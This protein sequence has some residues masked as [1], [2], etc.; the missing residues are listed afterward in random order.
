M[1]RCEVLNSGS[2]NAN[3][4]RRTARSDDSDYI[5]Q[6]CDNLV[7]EHRLDH[8]SSLRTLEMSIED[9][10]IV[11]TRYATNQGLVKKG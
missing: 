8:D 3:N 1:I 11:E 6:V 7:V 2:E 10:T 5:E 9:R 4:G